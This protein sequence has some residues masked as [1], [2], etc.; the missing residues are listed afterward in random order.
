[1]PEPKSGCSKSDSGEEVP[2]QFVVSRGNAPEVLQLVEEALDGIAQAIEFGIDRALL[3]AIPLGGDVRLGA[4]FSNQFEDGF[5]I[6][7]AVGDGVRGRLEAS[8]QHGHGGFVGG[9]S[10]RQSEPERQSVTIDDGVDLRAQSSTRTA[11]GVIRAP[12]FP[13]A[14]CWWARTIEESMR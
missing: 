8:Q 6:V 4:V 11:D 1:M 9:L 13:P 10:G 14:A 3:F 12:F 7:S 2:G 5:G